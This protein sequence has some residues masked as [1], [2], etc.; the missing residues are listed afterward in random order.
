[1]PAIRVVVPV[2]QVEAFLPRCIE[3]LLAQT[4]ADFDLVL[5]DDGSPDGCG[6]L[7]DA[8][9]ARD[10]RVRVVHQKNGGLSA[11]RNAGI[12][13][14]P[15]ADSEAPRYL[16][17]VDADDEVEPDF[18]Q[19]LYEAAEA[20]GADIAVCGW[21]E[22]DEEG[23]PADTPPLYQTPAEGVFRGRALLEQFDGPSSP[24]YTVAWN[25]LYR[26]SLWQTLRYPAGRLHE[27]DAVAH[28][29][30]W[31]AGR[32]VCRAAPLC[33][34]RQ[35]QASIMHEGPR[36]GRFDGL[37]AKR[38]RY[39]FF[40]AHGLPRPACERV[41]AAACL[42]YLSLCGQIVAAEHAAPV[43]DAL[44][45]RWAAEQAGMRRLL[46]QL[47]RCGGLT[48]AQKL[49]C[50]K[51]CT[52]PPAALLGRRGYPARPAAAVRPKAARAKRAKPGAGAPGRADKP[53]AGPAGGKKGRG[54]T[55]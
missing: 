29:L 51:W 54:G 33:R 38:E 40:C 41:L 42:L 10:K 5:V 26:V 11:A 43:S 36:P 21:R 55:R 27:D 23:R 3:S 9:A 39:R 2:Y 50:A 44:L 8:A 4:F 7:C 45:S 32:V 19:T 6:A 18:L 47:A 13:L 17:F 31:Q 1:M 49:S 15:A 35:R 46:P 20:A 37:L 53:A 52:L 28:L 30:Y 12:A 48:A 25:K 24:Y 14:P 16:A 22:I 34:Y